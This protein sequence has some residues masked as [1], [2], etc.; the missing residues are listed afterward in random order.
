M[1]TNIWLSNKAQLNLREWCRSSSRSYA[2]D[3]IDTNRMPND[4][5][6]G[7]LKGERNVTIY[8]PWVSSQE[9]ISKLVE[10]VVYCGIAF[11][12]IT[13]QIET[14]LQLKESLKEINRDIGKIKKLLWHFVWD[15]QRLDYSWRHVHSSTYWIL[16]HI[17]IPN[18]LYRVLMKGKS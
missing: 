18:H 14:S 5:G 12:L 8:D 9:T 16:H 15:E 13:S 2:L 17:D 3:P 10:H 11:Y 7:F 4:R 1:K 6:D